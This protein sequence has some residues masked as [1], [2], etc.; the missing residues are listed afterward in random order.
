MLIFLPHFLLFYLHC[1]IMVLRYDLGTIISQNFW[2][3]NNNSQSF[4]IL[5]F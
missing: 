5:S 3:V 4:V 1:G 2:I